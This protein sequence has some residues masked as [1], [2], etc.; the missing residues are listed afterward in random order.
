LNYEGLNKLPF[1]Q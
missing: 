1:Y